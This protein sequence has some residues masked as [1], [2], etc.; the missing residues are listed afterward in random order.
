MV[1]TVTL[2]LSVK[3]ANGKKGQ[4]GAVLSVQ[5]SEKCP[6]VYEDACTEPK[7]ISQKFLVPSLSL[8]FFFF[9]QQNAA[10][11]QVT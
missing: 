6:M 5:V 7:G 8:L 3:H 10:C 2:T 1:L 9:A 4:S 11:L